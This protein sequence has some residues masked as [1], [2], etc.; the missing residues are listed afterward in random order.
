MTLVLEKGCVNSDGIL[1]FK[2]LQGVGVRLVESSSDGISSCDSMDVNGLVIVCA[3][4]DRKEVVG[5][6]GLIG[7]E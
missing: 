7:L 4:I 3:Q 1:G 6:V 2:S 5:K